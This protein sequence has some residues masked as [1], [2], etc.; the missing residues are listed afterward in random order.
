MFFNTLIINF[1]IYTIIYITRKYVMN[2]T[3]THNNNIIYAYSKMPREVISCW[4]IHGACPQSCADMPRTM[5]HVRTRTYFYMPNIFY[6]WWKL[7][8]YNVHSILTTNLAAVVCVCVC[9][10]AKFDQFLPARSHFKSKRSENFV[11]IAKFPYAAFRPLFAFHCPL[12]FYEKQ[13]FRMEIV[14]LRRSRSPP[15]GR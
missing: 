13:W 14:T 6:F 12:F 3:N 7:Y 8:S 10:R 11:R 2:Q 5:G 9:A 4:E 15:C 1:P